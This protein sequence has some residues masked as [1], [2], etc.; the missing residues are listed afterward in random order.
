[1]TRTPRRRYVITNPPRLA[2]GA[3]GSSGPAP[4]SGTTTVRAR[5]HSSA[6]R[7]GRRRRRGPRKAHGRTLVGQAR[8]HSSHH[9]I[10]VG[11]RD[12]IGESGIGQELDPALEQ[13]DQKQDAGALARAEQL[14]L[15][16]QRARIFPDL[17]LAPRRAQEQPRERGDEHRGQRADGTN[18]EDRHCR[19]QRRRHLAQSGRSVSATTV[20]SAASDAPTANAVHGSSG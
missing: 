19:E 5:A 7:E 2:R 10:P 13:T 17:D 16:E 15:E 18:A 3:L 8:C 4:P 11:R 6:R 14:A 1:M 9:L 12:G 20:A